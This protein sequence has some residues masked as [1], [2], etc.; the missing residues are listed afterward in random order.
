[1]GV[2]GAMKSPSFIIAFNINQL[3]FS[4]QR[5][6]SLVTRHMA[7]NGQMDSKSE[8]L[9]PFSMVITITGQE[10]HP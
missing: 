8:Y 6:K 9:T 5:W 4:A 10:V 2:T 1:M 3:S 7:K